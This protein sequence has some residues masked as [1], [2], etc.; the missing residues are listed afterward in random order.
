MI[1]PYFIAGA[2]VAG[3]GAL[4][5]VV[6]VIRRVYKLEAYITDFHF[7]KLGKLLVLACLTYLYFNIN[8]YLI[9]AFTAT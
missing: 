4:V 6:Y 2:F 7:D 5:A 1:E 9:P 8:E 3:V